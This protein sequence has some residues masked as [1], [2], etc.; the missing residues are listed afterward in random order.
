MRALDDVG[1]VTMSL[2]YPA[3]APWLTAYGKAVLLNDGNAPPAERVFGKVLHGTMASN[4][5][6]TTAITMLLEKG[7]SNA[8]SGSYFYDRIRTP[9]ALNGSQTGQTLELTE[10]VEAIEAKPGQP[11]KTATFS[12]RKTGNDLKGQWASPAPNK[13]LDVRLAP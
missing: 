4:T 1:D 12:L 10:T 8:I 9:I 6:T 11:E 3:L 7:N 2:P 13:T 5:A